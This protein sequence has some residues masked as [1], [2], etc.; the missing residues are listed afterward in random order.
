MNLKSFPCFAQIVAENS[1]WWIF[2]S[3]NNSLSLLIHILQIICLPPFPLQTWE[4]G[5]PRKPTY[6][7]LGKNF[8]SESFTLSS[9]IRSI[10]H[11]A[12]VY[13]LS[14][15]VWRFSV[16]VATRVVRVLWRPL[17][18]YGVSGDWD[19]LTWPA[20]GRTYDYKNE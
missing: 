13:H 12:Q 16:F 7:L 10:T 19:P 8:T 6:A 18:P 20:S 2:R 17:W 3:R 11:P 5:V 14:L 1:C 4:A 9:V 15:L